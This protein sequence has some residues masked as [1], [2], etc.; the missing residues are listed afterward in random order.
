MH[1]QAVCPRPRHVLCS[2]PAAKPGGDGE[3]PEKETEKRGNWNMKDTEVPAPVRRM[4]L[5]PARDV[6]FTRRSFVE[7][8]GD[9]GLTSASFPPRQ[10]PC[11]SSAEAVKTR[12]GGRGHQKRAR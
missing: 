2:R 6:A 4:S 8:G 12:R 10:T 3:T 9:C 7:D 1:L 5:S 11:A